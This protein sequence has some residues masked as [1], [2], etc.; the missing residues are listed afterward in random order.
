MKTQGGK[1]SSYHIKSTE[2]PATNLLALTNTLQP[3]VRRC[4]FGCPVTTKIISHVS[5]RCS[6]QFPNRF[7]NWKTDFPWREMIVQYKKPHATFTKAKQSDYENIFPHL[8]FISI[9]FGIKPQIF[10]SK[11]IRAFAQSSKLT[12]WEETL[13]RPPM[14]SKVLLFQYDK[15]KFFKEIHSS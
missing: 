1:W 7:L 6:L 13:T 8:S 2:S 12:V 3:V 14:A 5:C 9:V 4:R 10:Y 15:G 11:S